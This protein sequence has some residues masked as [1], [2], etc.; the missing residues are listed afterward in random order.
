MCFRN[1]KKICLGLIYLKAA[2]LEIII[3]ALQFYYSRFADLHKN[4]IK[5]S[6]IGPA[7]GEETVYI[8]YCRHPLMSD[9]KQFFNRNGNQNRNSF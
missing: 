6:R 3:K 5:K 4:D 2:I 8:M 1:T 9:Q 7:K